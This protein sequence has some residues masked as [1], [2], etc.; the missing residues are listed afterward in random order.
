MRCVALGVFALVFVGC[1][2]VDSGTDSEGQALSADGT[3]AVDD[4]G[5]DGT[6]YDDG[7]CDG[8]HPGKAGEP[9][10]CAADVDACF[11]A[12]KA[13]CGEAADD[14]CEE[15]FA[16]CEELAE[17]C[18][19]PPPPPPPC[20]ADVEACFEAAKAQCGDTPDAGCEELFAPCEE[21]A[22]GCLP[23][24]PLDCDEVGELCAEKRDE[25][26]AAEPDSEICAQITEDCGSMV[27]D[28]KSAPPPGEL[29][30]PPDG[31]ELP[32]EEL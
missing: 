30:P 4:A 15:L 12:A 1:N 14:A 9:P 27:E 24:P 31:A 19:R 26:C 28:C 5:D 13:Q 23:P 6:G 8:G 18:L 20:A 7:P 16:P 11:A 2:G 25:V 17:A 32:E 21:L 22:A 29:P 3:G 10:P